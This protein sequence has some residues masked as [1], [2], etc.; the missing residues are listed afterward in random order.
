[1]LKSELGWEEAV[2]LGRGLKIRLEDWWAGD[3]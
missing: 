3:D 1:M 2:A